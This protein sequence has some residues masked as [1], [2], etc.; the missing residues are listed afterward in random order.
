MRAANT[1]NYRMQKFVYALIE[2]GGHKTEAAITAGYKLKNRGLYSKRGYELCRNPKVKR[3]CM[4]LINQLEEELGVDAKWR[5][6]NLKNIV[7]WNMKDEERIAPD[8]AAVAI[9]GIAEINKMVG[10]YAAEKA[11]DYRDSAKVKN[12]IDEINPDDLKDF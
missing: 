5:L 9:R 2:N 6:N 10:G 4:E 7:N 11:P 8:K 3:F 1:I 12:I